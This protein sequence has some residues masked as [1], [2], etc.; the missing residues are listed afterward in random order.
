MNNSLTSLSFGLAERTAAEMAC[1]KL[2]YEFG[3]LVDAHKYEELGQ[4]FDE[5]AEFNRPSEPQNVIKGRQAIISNFRGRPNYVSVHL[6]SN[7]QVT[8]T[9]P[10]HATGHSH[11]IMY[12][13]KPGNIGTLGVPIA[14]PEARIGMFAEEFVCESGIWLF[15]RRVGR[16][17]MVVDLTKIAGSKT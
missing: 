15:S 3:R 8:A 2:V 14:N 5:N 13:A 10:T 11:L 17:L 16:M 12:T 1:V 9:S 4:L 7:I 6:F